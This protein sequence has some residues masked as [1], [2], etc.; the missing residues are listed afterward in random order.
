MLFCASIAL[1][2]AARL[3]AAPP[4]V[5]LIISDDQA[6]T[7]FGFMGHETIRTPN[8]DRLANESLVFVNGYV[9]ASLCCPSLASMVTGLS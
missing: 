1:T 5:V 4:N 8:L 3:A 6:W 9:P 7:D 2:L